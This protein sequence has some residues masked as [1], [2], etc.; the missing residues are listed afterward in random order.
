MAVHHGFVLQ[1]SDLSFA[2]S[3]QTAASGML[4]AIQLKRNKHSRSCAANVDLDAAEQSAMLPVKVEMHGRLSMRRNRQLFAGVRSHL[5]LKTRQGAN[6]CFDGCTLV[7]AMVDQA[8]AT[9][10]VLSLLLVVH[11]IFQP[12]AEGGSFNSLLQQ[13]DDDY[14]FLSAS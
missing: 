13:L 4:A 3:L 9:E 7:G 12:G 8:K 14:Q 6:S 2:G 5:S 1:L 10:R 11:D